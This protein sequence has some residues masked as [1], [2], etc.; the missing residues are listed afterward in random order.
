ML[1]S[2]FDTTVSD[3]NLGNMIIM[4]DIYSH[5]F[6]MFPSAFYIKLP[7]LDTIGNESI[8]YIQQSNLVFFGGTN[9]LAGEMEHY[10]QWGID[11]SN[12][13]QIR[14]V[15]LM[16]VGWWQ[17]QSHISEYTKKILQQV[18]HTKFMHSVRDSYTA[19]KLND[20]GI[21]NV[22]NT[23][24]PTLWNLNQAICNQIPQEKAEDVL[25]TFTNY[26]QDKRDIELFTIVKRNYRTVYLWVQGPEDYEYA[27]N[28]C[29]QIKFIDPN[30]RS[31]DDLLSST[32]SID[33]VGTRL[34]AGIRA[35]SFKRRAI[36]IGIDNRSIEMSRDFGLKVIKRTE[37]DLLEGEIHRKFKTEL[38]IPFENIAIWK[39][40]FFQ[41][42]DRK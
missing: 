30:L 32:S 38:H 20:L 35:M 39:N 8:R 7:Y 5:L 19:A 29:S 28:I 2:V 15:I 10:R 13:S 1:I 22:I 40:Q 12:A 18:L 14:N 11:F 16:G 6:Q 31:L 9:A 27:K 26:N 42:A 34:H 41:N 3:N 17:Y 23:G 33:Y 25:L 24:C 36:I 37:L 4:E 21:N